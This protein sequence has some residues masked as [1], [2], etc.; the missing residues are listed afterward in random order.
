M[1]AY[2]RVPKRSPLIGCSAVSE[3]KIRSNKTKK[4]KDQTY[5]IVNGIDWFILHHL[6][7]RF[8]NQILGINCKIDYPL[9]IHTNFDPVQAGATVVVSGFVK[10]AR[11]S[12]LHRNWLVLVA[13][14]LQTIACCK[15]PLILY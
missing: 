8:Q 14:V 10:P 4:Y 9:V 2:R 13:A 3:K 1:P 12:I 5:F 6:V 7:D 11:I 15:N